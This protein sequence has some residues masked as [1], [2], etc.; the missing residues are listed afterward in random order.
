MNIDLTGR[1]AVVT[2]STAGI[3]RAVAEGL[4]RA[5]A[6]VVINGR[7][8]DRVAA[9]LGELRALFPKGEFIGVVADLATSEGAA[10]LFA[11]APDADILVNNVGTGR[12]KSFFDIGDSEWTDLFELNVMSGIRASRHY[13]PNMTKRGW[14]R[15]VFISS[16]SALAIPKDMIDYAMTKTAQ[17]AVARGLAEEVGGTGVTVNSVLPGP[18]NSEIMSG[19]MKAAAEEQG[20]TQHEAEQQFIKTMRPTSLLNRF[21]TTE[22]VAN[23]VIY[24]CSE[25]ASGTTGT[26][27]RVDGGV[28]RTIA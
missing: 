23:L 1:K 5:G 19:W 26:S 25:Q 27:L 18:T 21:A 3:G 11:Q 20:T 28:V 24:V 2:G 14:G 12:A 6:A 16:E 7:R 8:A 17:L 22:E 4:A 10:E 15:V 9:T 13:V